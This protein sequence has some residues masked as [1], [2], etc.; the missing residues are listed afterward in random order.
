MAITLYSNRLVFVA[1]GVTN[2]VL[3]AAS[4]Y[5]LSGIFMAI[6]NFQDTTAAAAIIALQSGGNTFFADTINTTGSGSFFNFPPIIFAFADPLL[7][8][9][10]GNITLNLNLI[11]SISEMAVSINLYGKPLS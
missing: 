5:S 7:L 4:N 10:G 9:R 8:P 3:A 2:T 1:A 11:G 6:D